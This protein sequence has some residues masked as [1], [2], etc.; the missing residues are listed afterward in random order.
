MANFT[1]GE[2]RKFREHQQF[3]RDLRKAYG[4]EPGD[5]EPLTL[6][7]MMAGERRNAERAIQEV[8]DRWS[9]TEMAPDPAREWFSRNPVH[10]RD[11]P[12]FAVHTILARCWTPDAA[13]DLLTMA[14][15]YPEWPQQGGDRLWVEAFRQVADSTGVS[16][17][18]DS[19]DEH[20]GCE[21]DLPGRPVTIYRGCFAWQASVRRMS[22]TTDRDRAEWFAER[23][24]MSGQNRP[25]RVYRAEVPRRAIL[26]HFT[27]RGE[28]EVVVDLAGLC[29]VH[30][31]PR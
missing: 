10:D 1:S 12:A 6:E 16:T 11:L 14:W 22:W 24:D 31:M 3:Y 30:V 13:E 8:I 29:G 27:G 28:S 18:C 20:G 2:F 26:G 5:G 9:G 21:F 4:Y 7:E 15:V 17:I 25:R 19:E 23:G